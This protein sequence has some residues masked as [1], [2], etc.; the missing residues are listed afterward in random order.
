MT[1]AVPDRTIDIPP[2]EPDDE[3]LGVHEEEPTRLRRRLDAF[4]RRRRASATA[5]AAALPR[6]ARVL[7][8]LGAVVLAFAAFV[9]VFGGMRHTAR[10][11]RLEEAFRARVAAGHADRPNWSPVPGQAIATISIPSIGMFEVVVQD[12]TPELLK[13][14]P[15]HVL[16]T[17]LPGQRGNAV[18]LGRRLTDGG[19]FRHLEDLDKG[20][21][22]TVVTPSGA[23]VYSVA[24]V[25]RIADGAPEAF[26]PTDDARMTLVTSASSLVPE[27]R[28]VV[29]ALLQGAPQEP[30]ETPVVQQRGGDVGTSGDLRALVHLLPWLL[31]LA[32]ALVIWVRERRRVRSRWYRFLI[33]TP[34][35]VVLLYFVFVNAETLMPGVI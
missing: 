33:A 2:A 9:V 32:L 19:P 21:R 11:E 17:P 20:D 22:I 30:A 14:G 13:S 16:G 4:R 8:W 27:D 23:F 28:T 18:L 10:Q 1:R 26:R 24:Q 29:V 6:A 15:G 7:I 12:S 5:V 34:V 31:A 35:A 25:V 3:P